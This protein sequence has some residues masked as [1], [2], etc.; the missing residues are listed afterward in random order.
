[1]DKMPVCGTG[2]PGSI[3][4]EGTEVKQKAPLMVLFVLASK[5]LCLRTF[6]PVG[7]MFSLGEKT[8]E[9]GSRTLMNDSSTRESELVIRDHRRNRTGKG[10]GKL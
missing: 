9:T 6:V 7:D 8:V 4:G 10:S 5:L 2:A 1:M 3:P